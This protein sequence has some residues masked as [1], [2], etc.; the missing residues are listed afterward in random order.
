MTAVT[1]RRG[2]GRPVAALLGLV[3]AL[4]LALT[5]CTG[6]GPTA[7]G[8]AAEPGPSPQDTVTAAA[9]ALAD[10]GSARATVGLDGPTGPLRANGPARFEPFAADLTVDLG[11]RGAHVRVLGDDAW[12]RFG[13]S[14][15]WQA[16]S[17]G[18]LP[19]GAVTGALHA[20]AGL[21]DVV[22]QPGTEDV[23]GLPAVRY[24]GTVDL[25][26]AR[27]AAPDPAAATRVDELSGLVSPTPWFT[28]WL[29]APDAAQPDRG[30]LVQ[31]RLEPAGPASGEQSANAAVPGAVTLGFTEPGLPVEVTAP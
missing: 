27:A 4:S 26:A 3:L 15:G 25:A 23:E 20:T 19:V 8:P 13:G 30:R 14:P 17:T 21:R 31:L 2:R 12:V 24:T 18:L 1:A 22:A 7:S 28:A 29:G 11:T 6:G 16:L 5:V 9:R 10:A